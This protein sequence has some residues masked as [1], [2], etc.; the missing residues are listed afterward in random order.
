MGSCVFYESGDADQDATENL[1]Y[2]SG[3]LKFHGPKELAH[4]FRQPNQGTPTLTKS[5]QRD[6]E[7]RYEAAEVQVLDIELNTAESLEQKN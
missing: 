1:S 5:S 2:T 7:V 4:V 6:D 3:C